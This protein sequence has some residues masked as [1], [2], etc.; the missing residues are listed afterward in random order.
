MLFY[1]FF[2]FTFYPAHC[3]LP[4]HTLAQSFPSPICPS[5]SQCLHP[6]I[7]FT[8][9]LQVSARL[10][11]SLHT[12]SRQG[13]QVVE[14]ILLTGNSFGTALVPVIKDLHN[15]S[16]AHLQHI[17]YE[18]LVQPMYVLWLVFQA[19]RAPRVQGSQFCWSSCEFPT[20]FGL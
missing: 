10:K 13:T 15:E 6:C 19:P 11:S 20:Y 3:L 12:E 7:P 14:Y 8:L 9:V 2:L 5:L 17:C 18:A 4:C 1:L 16:D